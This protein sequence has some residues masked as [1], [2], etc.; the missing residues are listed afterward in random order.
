MKCRQS[1]STSSQQ[2]SASHLNIEKGQDQPH[3]RSK[4]SSLDNFDQ[5]IL[6]NI[7]KK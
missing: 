1:S 4:S 2:K 3:Q 5:S 6:G 7:S